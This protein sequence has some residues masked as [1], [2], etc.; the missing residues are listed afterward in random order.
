VNEITPADLS[1]EDARGKVDT[2]KALV[3]DA[4]SEVADL[5][6]GRAWLALGYPSWDA[7]CDAEFEGARIRLPREER[8]EVVGSLREAGLSVRAIA[9]ATGASVGN[10]HD[11]L[12]GVQN[13][14]PG[15]VTGADGKSYAPT[16]PQPKSAPAS[17]VEAV[18]EA[19]PRAANESDGQPE[20]DLV[21]EWI[22]SSQSVQDASYM[23]E[24]LKVVNR[25]TTFME[26]DA[27]RIGQLADEHELGVIRDLP[28]RAERW[29]SRAMHARSG[30]RV[31][32]GGSG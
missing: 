9:A 24:F 7:L 1:A 30:L 11:D 12:S 17:A 26:F 19:W 31:V 3:S 10:V 32:K 27:E 4:W 15:P 13:R 20:S 21:G 8:R 28:G 2:V 22:G 25:A 5:Y 23:H 29:V 18:T 16:R 14:T 6:R